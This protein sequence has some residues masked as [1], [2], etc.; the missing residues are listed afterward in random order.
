MFKCKETDKRVIGISNENNKYEKAL[1]LVKTDLFHL[2]IFL[3]I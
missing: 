3:T 2:D 1:Y